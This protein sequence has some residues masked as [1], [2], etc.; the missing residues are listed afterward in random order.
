MTGGHRLT[1]IGL[2]VRDLSRSVEFYCGAMGFDEVGRMRVDGGATAQLLDVPDLVLD[3]VYL[4]RD[5]IRL[6]L[7]SY[8]SPGVSGDGLPREMNALGFTHLSFRVDDPDEMVG[9]I[10]RA[11]GRAWPERTV[12]FDGGN[13]GLMVTD[14]DGNWLELIERRPK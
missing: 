10:E 8:P 12:K 7:L 4:H 6:E 3:L 5:G 2:C 13:R 1:H 14:P 9:Q 11:G